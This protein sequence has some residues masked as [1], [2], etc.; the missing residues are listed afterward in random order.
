MQVDNSSVAVIFIAMKYLSLLRVTAPL[1]V[2]ALLSARTFATGPTE[3]IKSGT[4]AITLS[5]DFVTGL[6]LGLI[7]FTKISPATYIANKHRLSAPITGGAF[8]AENAKTE[9]IIG[10]GFHLVKG[11]L[12]VS[13][14]DFILTI[15]STSGTATVSALVTA[16]SAFQGRVGLISFDASSLEIQTPVPVP[17]NNKIVLTGV[18][19]TLSSSGASALNS[20][21][22]TSAFSAGNVIGTADLLI[23]LAAK[24][25]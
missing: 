25:L 3:D 8:D 16:T 6:G 21:L 20:A 2:C 19:L 9:V 23:K 14:T 12:N 1:L 5:N 18:T 4:A 11:N 10:G 17:S 7:D 13:L 22:E 15:P 24:P